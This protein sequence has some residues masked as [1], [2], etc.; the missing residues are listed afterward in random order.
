MMIP[1]IVFGVCLLA[2]INGCASF[3]TIS[4]ARPGSPKIYSGTRLDYHAAQ[5]DKY[6]V[7]KFRVLPPA[8]PLL[9]MPLSFLLDTIA[10]PLTLSVSGYEIIFGDD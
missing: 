2:T 7:E 6:A 10:L 1:R 8:Q 5:G 9:D 3:D 4:A